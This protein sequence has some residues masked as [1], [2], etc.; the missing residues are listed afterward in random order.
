[1]KY[2]YGAAL[3]D[4]ESMGK[5]FKDIF[6]D[7]EGAA[8]VIHALKLADKVTG[9]PS[10]GMLEAGRKHFDLGRDVSGFKAMIAQACKEIK[11][12]TI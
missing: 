1:M 4:I 10:R 6:G 9:G 3:E 8:A 7:G 11:E 2:D 12:G 5:A